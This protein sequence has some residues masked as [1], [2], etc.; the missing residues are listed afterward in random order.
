MMRPL[1]AALWLSL[2]TSSA[3]MTA[4]CKDDADC[5]AGAR[6]CVEPRLPGQDMTG[7]DMT[8]QDMTGQ[9]M[10]E[11][12]GSSGPLTYHKDVRPMLD[13]Y[14]TRCHHDGGQGPGDFT[15][16]E[17]VVALAQVMLNAVQ[18]RRMPPPAAD[19][20][21]RDYLSS[22]RMFVDD[23]SV[24]LLSDWIAQGKVVGQAP[25]Q[26]PVGPAPEAV[27]ESPDLELRMT[28]PYTPTYQD[29][30]NANNEYRCFAL[31]HGQA[32]PFFI[33]ALHPIIDQAAIAHHVVLGKAKAAQ[34]PEAAFSPQGIDCIDDMSLL[35]DFGDGGGIFGAWAPGMEPVRF[36]DAGIKV[37]PDE[38]LILQ[39]HYYSN[40]AQT[41]GLSDQSGY[42]FK[43][44]KQ[45][46]NEIRMAPLGKFDFSIPPGEPAHQESVTLDL[47]VAVTLWG[48]FPHMHVLGRA[49]RM[50]VGQPEQEVC[51]LD[52]PRYDFHN[53]L[54][55]MFKE[56]LLIRARTPITFSCTWDNS[57]ENPNLILRPPQRVGYGERTDE[58]MCYAFSYI[59]IGARR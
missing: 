25:A 22:E 20:S 56:P 38:V 5:G 21:C 59:S 33:T 50:S 39:M 18:A 32:E 40:S 14:C 36:E 28:Q 29:A 47:P 15:K 45:V 46:R 43:T 6:A 52:G 48:V 9:D 1:H 54:T 4:G 55:Y 42:A 7:Q 34:T 19:P 17:T 44:A 13:Q 10:A 12:L 24:K 3:L 51:V 16:P 31:R 58:E 41:D 26:R 8:G 35:G 49:Y 23:A 37:S 57:L 11:D 30:R 2:A 27:L 53:Q